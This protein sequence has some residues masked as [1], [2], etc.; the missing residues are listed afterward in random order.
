M[1]LENF[2]DAFIG[3]RVFR[4][5]LAD[6][7]FDERLDALRTHL[8]SVI[9]LQRA[10]EKEFEFVH[11]EGCCHIFVGRDAADR[12]FVHVDIIGDVF[13]DKRF[14][15]ADPFLK[16]AALVFYNT[17]DDFVQCPLP[18]VQAFDKPRRR[19]DFFVEVFFFLA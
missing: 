4:I 11:A 13:Q 6:A 8:A 19:T 16:K 3:E 7:L 17:F 1:F 14:E 5:F 2:A 12:G 18:L 15:L 9:Q 10:V